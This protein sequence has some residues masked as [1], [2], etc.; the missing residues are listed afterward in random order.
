MDIP[1]MFKRSVERS[2]EQD[3][4]INI[5]T[6]DRYTYQEVADQVYKTANG[7]TSLGVEKGDRVTICLPNRPEHVIL[8]L[9]TQVLGAVAVPFNFR[10]PANDVKYHV[11]D[12]DPEVFAF[13]AAAR[14]AV[15]S[16]QEA[17][18]GCETSVYVGQDNP[19][20]ATRFEE[21]TGDAAEVA[22]PVNHDD[23][24]VILYTSGTTGDPKGVPISHR[25]AVT[26]VLSNTIG[27]RYYL[28]ESVLSA[29]PLY[30]TIG[31]HGVLS[32]MLCTSGTYLTLP[33]FD[34]EEYIEALETESL[35]GVYEA[36]TIFN[37]ILNSEAIAS[38]DIDTV[39]HVIYGGAPMSPSLC[40]Q[41]R[42]VFEPEHMIH[43]YGNTETYDPLSYE[44]PMKNGKKGLFHRTR[45]V[46]IGAKDP[47]A[48]VE[49]GE[50]GEL[51]VHTDSPA[52]FDEYWNKPEETDKAIIDG[53]FFTDDAAYQDEEGHV[54]ITGRADDI[55]IS[56]GENI[57]PVEV[58]DV[59]TT[60]ENV[61]DAAVIG[62]PDDEWGEVVTAYVQQAEDAITTE[63]DLDQWCL[64]SPDLADF[65]R[66]RVCHF[67]D[68]IPRNPSGKIMQYKLREQ[69]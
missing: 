62:T 32:T 14:E 68:E 47:T 4:I 64:D 54:M 25:A 19:E 2:P 61:V 60:H 42:D 44:D 6:G 23:L 58:E 10:L 1:T 22:T 18:L 48:E 13:D 65:K 15:V 26:R 56:G 38:A 50:E 20:F 3:A 40:E 24:S 29:M 17:G 16:A 41:V 33:A 9:A 57:H 46:E 67:V 45:L 11:R 55:I 12:S 35:T 30:H 37:N 69:D 52:A 59:L 51:I 43:L 8:Y 36:P 21:V 34:P 31:L 66:P 27:Q 39:R 7:L 28:R 5:E 53:W 63:D 49:Q